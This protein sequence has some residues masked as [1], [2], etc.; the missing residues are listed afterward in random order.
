MDN[1]S[2][3]INIEIEN[4]TEI[5]KGIPTP[6]KLPFLSSLELAGTAALLHNFYNAIENILKQIFISD[7][8]SIP[9][10]KS[11]HK[12]LVESAV[13]E[14]IITENCKNQLSNYLAFRH[15][16]SH[17]YALDLYSERIEPLVKNM[18][19]VFTIFRDEISKYL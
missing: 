13:K 8:I 11:W 1:L 7:K 9:E 6:S 14:K 18:K 4:I 15:F 2:Q 5:I 17:A 10:G 19:D 3:K 12:E 16:F